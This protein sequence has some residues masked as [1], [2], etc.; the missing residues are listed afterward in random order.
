MVRTWLVVGLMVVAGRTNAQ[1]WTFESVGIGTKPEIALMPD[2]MPRILFMEEAAHGTVYYAAPGPDGGVTDTV[3]EGYFYGPMGLTI[4]A[5]GNGHIIY[6]DHQDMQ[7]M[8]SLGD[9]VYGSDANGD[10]RLETISDA[11][12]DG[13]DGSIAVDNAG[14]V[15]VASIDPSQFG[16]VDGV[17][18]GVRTG[19][20]WMVR[21]VGSGP[22]PYEFATSVAV[23]GDN[24]VHTAY[25]NGGEKLD[26]LSP[27]SNL[28]YARAGDGAAE[29]E[30]EEVDTDGDVGKV[31][32][33]A[34]D[35]ANHPHSAYFERTEDRA[36]FVKY[37]HRSE[38]GT[39]QSERVA[40]LNDV[41]IAFLW[42]LHLVS[43]TLDANDVPH[44]A[45]SDRAALYYARLEVDGTWQI[46]R[47]TGPKS[48][49]ALGQQA[50]LTLDDSARLTSRTTNC[51]R[52]RRVP[53]ARSCTPV[54]GLRI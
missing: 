11:G 13:W 54:A 1:Q 30:L 22:L 48:G 5:D 49:A 23:D 33:L 31:A 52:T 10:W 34:L 39:W 3:S 40:A 24:R 14:R 15:H 41:L 42:A 27:I 12:H 4:D 35:A 50:S 9:A 47:V 38:Q 17:E 43:L 44:L 19:G 32:S 46:E 36:D 16:S 25:H 6:H 51:H 7:F 20:G 53:Q 2:G 21:P 45:F 29:F 8:L 37:A 28:M 18:C 26:L